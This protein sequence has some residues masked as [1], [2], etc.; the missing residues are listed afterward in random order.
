MQKSELSSGVAYS[1]DSMSARSQLLNALL[2]SPR[3]SCW[4]CGTVALVALAALHSL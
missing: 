4:S 2:M 3:F 1:L